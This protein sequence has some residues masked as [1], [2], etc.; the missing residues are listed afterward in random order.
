MNSYGLLI[1]DHLKPSNRVPR[2]VPKDRN[3]NHWMFHRATYV[4]LHDHSE[5]NNKIQ[6]KYKETKFVLVHRHVEPNVCDIKP[7]NGKGPVHTVN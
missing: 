5:G 4:L 1:S 2:K 7:V 3:V 6:D